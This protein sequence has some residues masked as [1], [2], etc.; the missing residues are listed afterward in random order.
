MPEEQYLLRY[1]RSRHEAFT[2]SQ[3]FC[4]RQ[5]LF[6][7]IWAELGGLPGRVKPSFK[8]KTLVAKEQ[9]EKIMSS[10]SP[11]ACVT[12]TEEPPSRSMQLME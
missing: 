5:G 11:K 9:G 6:T 10:E 4:L 12:K 7:K 1:L 8:K 3:C 2:E